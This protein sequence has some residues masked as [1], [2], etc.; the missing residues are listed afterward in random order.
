MVGCSNPKVPF[1]R[2]I[3]DIAKTLIEN[4]VIVLTNGCASY[5]LMKL[6][7]CARSGKVF[8]GRNLQGF[9]GEDLP[10]VW[11]VGECIDNTRSTQ[12]FAAIA[13][14]LQ[15]PLQDM[16]FAMS[17]PE[18]GNE[19][20][21]DA[22]LAFRLNGINSYHCVEAPIFGSQ[23]VTE[24]LKHGSRELLGSVMTVDVDPVSLAHRIIDDMKE[25]RQKLGWDS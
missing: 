17:S 19:K 5:P 18:W 4:N 3:A 8:A 6:G 7:Y 12:I 2:C 15:I 16:P 21:I 9:L 1:E 24:F 20:G 10:P 13:S 25:K 14:E 11:H 23:N 22:A